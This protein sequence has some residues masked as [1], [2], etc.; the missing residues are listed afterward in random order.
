MI[1]NNVRDHLNIIVQFAQMLKKNLIKGSAKLLV[2][3]FTIILIANLYVK[4]IVKA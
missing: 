1:V 2:K 4:T 3:R